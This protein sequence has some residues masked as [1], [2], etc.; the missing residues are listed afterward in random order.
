MS[1][2]EEKAGAAY[3]AEQIESEHFLQWVFEQVVEASRMDPSKVLPLETKEDARVIASNTFQQL[4]W[5]VKR[6]LNESRDFFKGFSDYLD[7]P[8]V[9]DWLADELL[10]MQEQVTGVPGREERHS[11]KPGEAR[12][13]G[14][15]VFNV[16]RK[17][18]GAPRVVGTFSSRAEAERERDAL[19]AQADKDFKE[20]RIMYDVPE[21]YVEVA[22]ASATAPRAAQRQLPRRRLPPRHDIPVPAVLKYEHGDPNAN[23]AIETLGAQGRRQKWRFHSGYYA[24]LDDA[25][26]MSENAILFGEVGWYKGVRVVDVR[27][28]YKPVWEWPEP[29]RWFGREGRPRA[30]ELRH[31]IVRVVITDV[32]GGKCTSKAYDGRGYLRAGISNPSDCAYV[33]AKAEEWWPGV[34]VDHEKREPPPR[35]RR[36]R[37]R[38]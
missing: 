2:K 17:G 18:W 11:W 13:P 38:R 19:Q 16:V 4:E 12:E 15:R 20:G 28:G 24:T 1:K 30:A 31:P 29:K 26:A 5:D 21:F 32:G 36:R 14:K 9:I 8:E 23:Y 6:D 7:Q 34:P 10:F 37:R 27:R 35:Q 22:P 33:A 25:I 3:A